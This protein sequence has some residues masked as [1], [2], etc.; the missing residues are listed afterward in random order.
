MVEVPEDD[1]RKREVEQAARFTPEALCDE[2]VLARGPQ[3][4]GRLAAVARYTATHPQ[5]FK[6]RPSAV[7]RED[8]A[9]GGGAAL[10]CFHLEQGGDCPPPPAL[11]FEVPP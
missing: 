9:E 4:A 7:M 1:H 3:Y 6:G 5:L 8:H 10:R 11:A 2:A